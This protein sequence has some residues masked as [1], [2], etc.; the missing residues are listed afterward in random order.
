VVVLPRSA[1]INDDTVLIANS[2]SE[3][4]VRSVKVL[5]AEPRTV[6]ITEGITAGELIVTTRLDAPIPGTLLTINSN[7]AG[8]REQDM[9]Q[10]GSVKG[11]TVKAGT[12]L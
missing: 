2:D 6:Y 11:T 5:R 8:Q 7:G 10:E 4:E 9:A 1:L 12:E 3:L